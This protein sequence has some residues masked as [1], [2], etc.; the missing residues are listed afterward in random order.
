MDRSYPREKCRSRRGSSDVS[1]TG[2]VKRAGADIHKEST[3]RT[4][5]TKTSVFVHKLSVQSVC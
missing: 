4:V 3:I 1:W 5:C 2:A